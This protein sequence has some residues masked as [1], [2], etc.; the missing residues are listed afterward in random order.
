MKLSDLQNKDIINIENGKKVG[1]IIDVLID[2]NGK[3]ESLIAERSK[4]LGAMFNST[5]IEIKW[6]QIRKIGA[7]VILVSLYEEK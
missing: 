1:N 5:D 6:N 7:D 4:F 2:E 3:L